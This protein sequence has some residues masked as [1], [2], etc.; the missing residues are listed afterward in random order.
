MC[1]TT[2][3]PTQSMCVR[4]CVCLYEWFWMCGNW[5]NEVRGARWRRG[6]RG[7]RADR[8]I[9]DQPKMHGEN[10]GA[11]YKTLRTKTLKTE[12]TTTDRANERTNER[13]RRV[14][15]KP[16][17]KLFSRETTAVV[18]IF[19]SKIVHC[20]ILRQA[21]LLAAN[22]KPERMSARNQ[23]LRETKKNNNNESQKFG[24]KKMCC[25][26]NKSIVK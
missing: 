13:E 2:A 23:R 3:K 10:E 19:A 6:A 12:R 1:D 18:A 20:V 15:Y 14:V 4:T 21:N 8:A 24:T 22:E 16:H 11:L 9:A 26:S 7:R 5:M 25:Y 17:P